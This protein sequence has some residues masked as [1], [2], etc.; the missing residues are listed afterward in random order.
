MSCHKDRSARSFIDAAALHAYDTVLHD[1][2]DPDT[3]LSAQFIEG[4]DDIRDLHGLAVDSLRNTFLEGHGH[5]SDF[6][7]SC[8]R[9]DGE[10]KEAVIIRRQ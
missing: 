7:R 1:I 4:T 3:I 6:I 5:I 8:L 10:N 2:D 9:S